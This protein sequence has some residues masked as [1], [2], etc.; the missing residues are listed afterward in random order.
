M[1]EEE[2]KVYQVHELT[3]LIR[4]VCRQHFPSV[5]VEGEVLGFKIYSTGTA[6]FSLK[7]ESAQLNAILFPRDLNAIAPEIREKI[8]DGVRI[9]VRGSIDF[10]AGNGKLTLVARSLSLADGEGEL[11]RRFLA[12]KEKLEKEGLFAKE[13]K[14]KLPFLPRRIGV[15]TS[16]TGAVIHDILHVLGRRFPN[17][18]LLLAPVKVQG[19]DAALSIA[20]AIRFMNAHYGA[21]M[22]DGVDL[23]IVGRGGGSI[24]DL[25]AFNEEIVVRAVA[26]SAL[27]VISAVGHET[28]FTLCDFAADVRAPTPSAAAELAV[29]EKEE[30]VRR[31][32]RQSELLSSLMMRRV[33]VLRA[34]L[35][36]VEAASFFSQPDRMFESRRQ[37]VDALLLRLQRGVL[38]AVATAQK[39]IRD[40][41]ATLGVARVR[42]MEMLRARVARDAEQLQAATRLRME[43]ERTRM[44]TLS[45][46]MELLS[47]LA[48]L[49]RG[50]TLTWTEEGK[51]IRSAEGVVAGQK[52]VTQWKDGRVHS[53]VHGG[54][55]D[56]EVK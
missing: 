54:K 30:L 15:V 1:A 20:K 37:Q 43:R 12:L 17:I 23:L 50:Y 13:R 4:G 32:T 28:D 47:P 38:G 42:L 5:C 16:P 25:W 45:R 7:D 3:T 33:E 55:E 21:E 6:Y 51:L 35:R 19:N 22:P 34:R 49:S 31:V 14:R 52:M 26:E 10:F 24:E 53:S 48:V 39:R 44:Q 9:Q 11:M 56:D 36:A 40:A 18:Q 2:Q 41:D 29:P 8:K 46:Q 27:P